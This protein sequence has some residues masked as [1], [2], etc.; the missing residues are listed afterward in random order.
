[1][2]TYEN[3]RDKRREYAFTKSVSDNPKD[4]DA[5]RKIRTQMDYDDLKK[6][7]G[8]KKKPD[9]AAVAESNGEKVDGKFMSYATM[10][11]K[12]IKPKKSALDTVKDKVGRQN[13]YDPKRDKPTEAQKKAYAAHKAKIAKQDT[14]DAT[15]KASD[16]RYSDRHSNRGSD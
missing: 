15:E 5:A 6:Q 16:G 10:K 1:M 11:A 7:I 13:I 8:S 9:K 12:G 4:Q 2:I 14:R 3:F